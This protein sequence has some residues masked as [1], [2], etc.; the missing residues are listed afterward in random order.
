MP[1]A[2]RSPTRK[3]SPTSTHDQVKLL[4]G[5]NPQIPMGDGDAPVQAYIAA[6][7]GWKRAV[8]EQ[9]DALIE[10]HVPKLQKAVK[11]N[12]PFYGVEGHGWFLATHCFTHFV[13]ITWF[14]GQALKPIPPG[15][16][17]DLNAR[18]LDIREAGIED[19]KQLVSWIKQAASLPGWFSHAQ[20]KAPKS[21]PNPE[22]AWFFE[23]KGPWHAC[24]ARLRELALDSGLTEELKWGHPCY[25]LKGKNVFLMHGFNDYCALLF[26]KGALLKDDHGMLVQQTANVQSARQIRFTSEQQ[27]AK[28]APVL[29]DYIQRA[30]A[31]EKAGSKVQLKQTAE[32]DMPAELI[33]A[34]KQMPELKKAFQA[35]TPGRQ[36]GYLL[37]FGGAKQ[38]ATREARI[39]KHVD[40]ILTGKGLQD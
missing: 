13:R 35:L 11:W 21:T 5:G 6:M 33:K 27:I 1:T 20:Q 31:L 25:T 10:R 8:G 17:K 15:P 14:Q 32:F 4:S 37:F 30:I 18:Y 9:L 22:V 19:E 24:Y 7:P 3:A 16:S 29:R 34:F 28:L 39:E 2:K 36:R 12:S 26:H 40:R 23:K 38:S